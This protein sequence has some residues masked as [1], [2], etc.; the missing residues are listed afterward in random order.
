MK[1]LKKN[2]GPYQNFTGFYEKGVETSNKLQNP[3]NKGKNRKV[4]M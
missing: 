2:I 1:A 4:K 3:Q